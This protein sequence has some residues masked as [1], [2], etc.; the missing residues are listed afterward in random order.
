VSGMPNLFDHFRT[1]AYLRRRQKY[2]TFGK[3]KQNSYD[4]WFF[5]LFLS[6]FLFYILK[7]PYQKNK[8]SS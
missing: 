4:F 7:S 2:K 8:D 5:V 1:A 3:G 6:S